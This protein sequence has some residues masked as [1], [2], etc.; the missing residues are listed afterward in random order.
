MSRSRLYLVPTEGHVD[1]ALAEDR[2][3]YTFGSFFAGLVAGGSERAATPEVT[4][5]ATV[6]ALESIREGAGWTSG[7]AVAVALDEGLGALRRAGVDAGALRHSNAPRSLFL[8]RLL[9]ATDE[10][11]RA[12][13]IFDD[14]GIGWIA[15]AALE[16]A[17]V[18][19]L[20]AAVVIDG[21]F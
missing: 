17:R 3:A 15:A 9:D 14:R 11:F 4:R 21:L 7:H 13:K 20:P 6:L 16:R 19:E 8:A 12:R 5:L 18:E 2:I 10:M 1:A